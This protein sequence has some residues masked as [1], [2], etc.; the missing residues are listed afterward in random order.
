MAP[1]MCFLMMGRDMRAMEPIELVFWGVMS[2]GVIA[3]FALAY[4]VNVWL[5]AMKLKHGLMTE[6]ATGGSGHGAGHAMHHGSGHGGA[7]RSGRD[8][9]A[10]DSAV[11]APQ[12]AAVTG[13]SAIALLVGMVTPANFVNLRLSA[14]DVG[15]TIMPPA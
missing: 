7:K 5:V 10:M 8:A 1:V 14:H 6:R 12:L 4:P 13:I 2:L 11:T 9:H 3:G 15:G